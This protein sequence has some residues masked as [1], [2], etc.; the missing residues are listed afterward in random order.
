MNDIEALQRQILASSAWAGDLAENAPTD[1][2]TAVLRQVAGD[3][4]RCAALLIPIGGCVVVTAK[5]VP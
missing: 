4:E 2:N 3:L 1:F 5:E